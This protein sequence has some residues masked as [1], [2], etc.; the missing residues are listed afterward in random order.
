MVCPQGWSLPLG[1]NLA[2]RGELGPQGW[3]LSPRGMFTP[4]FTPR[5]E[6]SLLFRRMEGRSENFTPQGITFPLGG[7]KSLL[8]DNFAPGGQSL[9]LG[10]KLRLGLWHPGGIRTRICCS[11]GE[12][13]ASAP[14]S[15]AGLPDFFSVRHTKSGK[16]YVSN[17]NKLYHMHCC[18]IDPIYIKL[19][20]G[21]HD[22][23]HIPKVS[24]TRSS[25]IN[26]NWYFWFAKIPSGNHAACDR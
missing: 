25:K 22:L 1:V 15:Q 16:I 14:Y 10:T 4:S 6:H 23:W 21:Q 24:I 3:T 11:W 2:P 19:P 5:G 18:K 9:P 13:D 17:N 8:W 7:Q 20:K 12:R 26:Q